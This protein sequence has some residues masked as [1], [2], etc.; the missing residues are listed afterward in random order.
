[1]IVLF[2]AA[3]LAGCKKPAAESTTVTREQA[4]AALTEKVETP[5]EVSSSKLLGLT[6]VEVLKKEGLKE[7][8]PEHGTA[9]KKWFSGG[10]FFPATPFDGYEWSR[11]HILTFKN[12]KVVKHEMVDRITAHVSFSSP[13]EP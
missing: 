6:E 1:M 7:L 8:K 2:A 9:D 13:D 4:I 5:V 11:I 3:F 10:V 12:D